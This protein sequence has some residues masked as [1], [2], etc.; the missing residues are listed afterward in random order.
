M[1]EKNNNTINLIK[2]IPNEFIGTYNVRY[3]KKVNI[4]TAT[5]INTQPILFYKKPTVAATA[6]TIAQKKSDPPS[7]A[8][9]AGTNLYGF[10]NKELKGKRFE[11]GS[12]VN[13]QENFDDGGKSDTPSGLSLIHI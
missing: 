8:F 4:D 7:N 11:T 5:V 1:N 12:A 9:V 2:N 3:S 10:V 6:T 13:T